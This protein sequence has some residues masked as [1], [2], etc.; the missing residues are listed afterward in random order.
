MCSTPGQVNDGW[1]LQPAAGE[2]LPS[3]HQ[4]RQK[5]TNHTAGS[6]EK[7]PP[8]HLSYPPERRRNRIRI[9]TGETKRLLKV[10]PKMNFSHRFF[11]PPSGRPFLRAHFPSSSLPRSQAVPR[12]RFNME[13]RSPSYLTRAQHGARNRSSKNNVRLWEDGKVQRP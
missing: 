2:Q 10:S 4:R 6:G 8:S 11:S 7:H 12:Q 5:T 1:T 13:Q 3:I 9:I